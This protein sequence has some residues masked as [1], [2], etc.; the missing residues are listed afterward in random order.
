MNILIGVCGSISAYKTYDVVRGLSKEGH[1]VKVILTKG[2]LHFVKK[3]TFGY[4]GAEKVYTFEDDFL[5]EQGV[6]HIEL[7]RWCDKLIICPLSANSLSKFAHGMCDDLLG[8]VFLAM[9]S[10]TPILLYPAMNSSMLENPI[11]QANLKKCELLPNIIMLPTQVGE[12]V[13][14]EIGRGKLLPPEQII[15]T[16]IYVTPFKN[17]NSKRILITTGAT[18]AP[19]DPVRY[20]TNPSSGITGYYLAKEALSQGHEVVV[21]QGVGSTPKLNY[22]LETPRYTLLKAETTRQMDI[23][24]QE[25][26]SQMDVYISAAAISD[27][28]FEYLD[29][30]VKKEQLKESL[31]IKRA[32]DILRS[33][34]ENK[35]ASQFIVGF[36][37]E[38]DLTEE[39]LLKKWQEKPVDLL[40]GTE[41]HSGLNDSST[42]MKG[43]SGDSANYKFFSKGKGQFEG[44]LSKNQLAIQILK[45]AIQ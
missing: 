34:V 19:L 38:T 18:V 24:V 35:K 8:C 25:L 12:M 2:A 13:C 3:E 14:K 29:K 5:S 37:A 42:S 39:I 30:K 41:V 31:L 32:K 10:K 9:S 44:I 17:P 22:F 15:E 40:I 36:A 7:A 1:N 11:T 4:L 21:I 28:E 16:A 43:F 20:L 26:I 33:V 6:L 27:I 23:I 45:E